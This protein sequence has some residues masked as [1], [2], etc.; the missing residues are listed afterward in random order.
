MAI[1]GNKGEWS[2]IYTL[3]RLLGEGK[4]YAGDANLNK[5]DLYYPILNVIREE[6]KKYEYKPDI[7]HNIV[8]IDEN[9]KEYLRIPMQRFVNESSSLLK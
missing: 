2:E 3:F 7:E 5:M 4:V 8:V 9:G 1:T 6:S